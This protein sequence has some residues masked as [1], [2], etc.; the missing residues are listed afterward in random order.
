MDIRLW[1]SCLSKRLK[2]RLIMVKARFMKLFRVFGYLDEFNHSK[3]N[4]FTGFARYFTI[5]SRPKRLN[6]LNLS[7]LLHFIHKITT[8]NV[9]FKVELFSIC[10]LNFYS[11]F[12]KKLRL[13]LWALLF[14]F[15]WRDFFYHVENN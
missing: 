10:K 6:L 4:I 15:Q 8:L 9:A 3:R 7:N 11:S 12:R 14:W 1:Y 13:M 2:S 5:Y